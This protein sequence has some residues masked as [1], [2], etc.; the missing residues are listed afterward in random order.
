ME[1][2]IWEAGETMDGYGR[3]EMEKK[4]SLSVGI[5]TVAFLSRALTASLS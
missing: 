5:S 2:I 1:V 4:I 3:A